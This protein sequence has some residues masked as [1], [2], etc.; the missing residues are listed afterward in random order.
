MAEIN[1][2]KVKL[3]M[4]CLLILF[5]L[6][7]LMVQAFVTVSPAIASEFNITPSTVSM[8]VTM[9]TIV[10]GVCSVIYGALSD[11]IPVRK[12][13]AFGIGMFLLGTIIG[14]IFQQTFFMIVIARAVQ[15]IG[16]AAMSSLYL[17]MAS[18]YFEGKEKIKY[19]AYFTASFQIAQALGVLAGGIIATYI[20]WKMLFVISLVSVIFIPAIIKY[21]PIEEKKE[22]RKIDLP[23]MLLF[24]IMIVLMTLLLDRFTIVLLAAEVTAVIVFILYIVKNESAFITPT[25]FK[26]NKKYTKAIC[27]VFVMY[28]S[29]FVFAFLYTFIVNALYGNS[30]D[31]VS[32]ILLPGYIAAAIVGGMGGRIIAKLGRYKAVN[33][34][35]TLI[36][37]G[38]L[39]TGLFMESGKL[40]LSLTGI[41]FFAGF[42][43]IYSPMIDTVTNALPQSEVGRGIGL[44]D[45]TIN[46]S[47]SIGV[48]IGGR[49]MVTN[50]LE[51][52]QI[53]PI[54]TNVNIYGNIMLIFALIAFISLILFRKNMK[55]YYV[56]D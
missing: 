2:K 36:T 33:A 17:V 35:M 19:F 18:R 8:V 34:G 10:L 39:L 48:A 27:I 56:E 3:L 20:N 29:Q 41:L 4:P 54:S 16:Q 7:N 9:S 31:L 21:A 40:V 26:Q 5:I 53:L 55:S 52:I 28:L 38:L 46:I 47:S 13:L 12:L 6:A 24:S 15:T 23:G 50:V 45:L 37:S 30:L 44:N 14:I 22:M 51:N 49:L 25:F 1:N 32:Y 42:N 11:Y 43:T